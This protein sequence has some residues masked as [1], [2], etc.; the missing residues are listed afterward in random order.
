L[1][2]RLQACPVYTT[3]KGAMTISRTLPAVTSGN[4]A[5]VGEASGSAD[6]I[7]G[8][9]LAMC[10]RQAIALAGAIADGELA[11]YEREHR[12]IMRLPQIM[13]QAMLL[14]DKSS[15][16]RDRTLRALARRPWVFDRMLSVHVGAVPVWKFGMN[17]AAEFGWGMVTG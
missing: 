5:L 14:M 3:V 10:F 15:L 13:G 17:T 4:V 6:A 11:R 9:G 1:K 8:E 2:K 12:R 16:I 7:T